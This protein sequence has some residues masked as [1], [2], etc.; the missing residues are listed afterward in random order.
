[1]SRAAVLDGYSIEAGATQT[2]AKI[3]RVQAVILG[4][5]AEQGPQT[6]DALND[7]YAERARKH[8]TVPRVTEQS[9][10]SRT[11]DLVRRGLV[12][13]AMEPGISRNGHKATRWALA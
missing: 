7:L 10:R 13:P 6:H 12:R 2:P 1:M 5:L 11:A 4:I 3:A 9:V 8:E